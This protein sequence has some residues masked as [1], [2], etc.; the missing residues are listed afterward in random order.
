MQGGPG[1]TEEPHDELGIVACDPGNAQEAGHCSTSGQRFKPRT[2]GQELRGSVWQETLGQWASFPLWE[3]K[4]ARCE[5]GCE[6][7]SHIKPLDTSHPIRKRQGTNDRAARLQTE[8]HPSVQ[9]NRQ[10]KAH[11]MAHYHGQLVTCPSVKTC[12]NTLS[13]ESRNTSARARLKLCRC[14]CIRG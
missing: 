11:L 14:V 3:G 2:R 10:R 1:P 8:S 9:S 13:G 4:L 6:N 5:E 12:A 7:S